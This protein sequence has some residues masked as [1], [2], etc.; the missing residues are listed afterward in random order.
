LLDPLRSGHEIEE[1]IDP[2]MLLTRKGIG[3]IEKVTE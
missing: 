3:G 1:R 2:L